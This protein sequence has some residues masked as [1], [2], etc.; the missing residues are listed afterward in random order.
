MA[1][2]REQVIRPSSGALWSGE[3]RWLID[4]GLVVPCVSN[5]LLPHIFGKDPTIIASS[6]ADEIKSPLPE[7][8]NHSIAHLARYYAIREGDARKARIEYHNVIK[9]YLLN[10]AR[11]DPNADADYV[12]SLLKDP[13]RFELVSFSDIARDLDYPRFD[14]PERNPLRLL[15]EMPLKLYLTTSQHTFLERALSQTNHKDPRTEIFYWDDSQRVIPSV[16]QREPGYEPSVERP[17]VYHLF[18]VDTYPSTLV[19]SEDDYISVLIRLAELKNLVKVSTTGKDG[20]SSSQY[21]IPSELKTALS[22]SGLL[23]LGYNVEDWDFRV[24]FRWLVDYIVPSRQGRSSIPE[25]FCLQVEPNQATGSD[26]EN[27]KI[28]E[29]LKD[30]FKINHFTV[31]WADTETCVHD[32]YKRWRAIDP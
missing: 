8:H 24:L 10:H 13:E 12:D 25:A 18:G 7:A 22:G 17:L 29:Y 32:L 26:E 15:A 27:R 21:D 19:L 5:Y 4:N 20:T 11:A 23:L 16:F 31:Y 9:G 2:R 6:W 3:T 30:F 1:L 28:R 14:L